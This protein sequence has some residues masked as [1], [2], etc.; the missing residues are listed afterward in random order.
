MSL[1]NNR[2][3]R[4][5]ISR[6]RTSSHRL[7]IET[8]RYTS[9]PVHERQC[10]FC[11]P[12]PDNPQANLGTE[13]HFLLY[14]VTFSDERRCLLR[15]LSVFLPNF[16]ALSEERKVS[17][18]LCPVNTQVAKLINKYIGLVFKIRDNIS[19]NRKTAEK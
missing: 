2:N 8:G 11:A 10:E 13:T 17:T 4:K 7:E 18:L 5:W 14:C 15:R 16:C 1:I 3:Q 19:E 9:T 6:L 12:D